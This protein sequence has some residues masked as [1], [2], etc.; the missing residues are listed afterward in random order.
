MLNPRPILHVCDVCMSKKECDALT[1]EKIWRRSRTTGCFA[2]LPL[3]PPER[4]YVKT[5]RKSLA[6]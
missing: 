4:A 6:L 3:G 5:V 1:R 2:C